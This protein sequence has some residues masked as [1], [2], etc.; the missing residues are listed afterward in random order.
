MFP[1]RDNIPSRGL[2][3]VTL[4]LIGFSFL[5]FLTQ[6]TSPDPHGFVLLFG[7][8]PA[9]YSVAA[10]LTY[11]FL[12]GG[13]FHLA[14]NMWFLFVFGDNL[15]DRLGRVNFLLFYLSGGIFAALL[16]VLVFPGSTIPLVG[17]SGSIAAVLG[18]YYY[19]FPYAKIDTLIFFVFI[20]RVWLS[21]HFML[22]Y[23][24]FIQV[25]SA[26]LELFSPEVSGI[27]FWAHV[28][29]FAFG[30]LLARIYDLGKRS[31]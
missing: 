1:L 29:G 3:I 28:G 2:H 20:S 14:S 15:E 11:Q 7:L 5:V 21:S 25:V 4:S 24:F 10:L 13:F 16:H 26:S 30:Y 27:A 17:A 19:F 6:S 18:A 12:H 9:S 23:W 8:V 22:G 31:R